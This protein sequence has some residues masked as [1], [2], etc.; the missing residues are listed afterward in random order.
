MPAARAPGTPVLVH[1]APAGSPAHKQGGK[2]QQH[3]RRHAVGCSECRLT[4]VSIHELTAANSQPTS[5]VK[6]TRCKPMSRLCRAGVRAEARHARQAGITITRQP[7][8][9]KPSMSAA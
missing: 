4:G 1:P 9:M 8:A 6:S 5:L 2:R 3:G 7:P